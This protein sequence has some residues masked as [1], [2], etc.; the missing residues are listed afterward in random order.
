MHV[1]SSACYGGGGTRKKSVHDV[2]L[3]FFYVKIS[4]F[5]TFFVDL[6]Y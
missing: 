3:D 5:L 2:A 6:Y 4:K 1:M